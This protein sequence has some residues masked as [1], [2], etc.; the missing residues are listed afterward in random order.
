MVLTYLGI[1]AIVI[2][3]IVYLGWTYYRYNSLMKH[4]KRQKDTAETARD[5]GGK[6]GELY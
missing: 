2:I 6:I 5:E 4:I 1:A 3:S